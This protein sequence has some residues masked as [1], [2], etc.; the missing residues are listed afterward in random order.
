MKKTDDQILVIF[1]ASGDLTERKLIPAVFDLYCGGF[2]P[3]HFAVTG[4]SRS[5]YSDEAYRQKVVFENEFILKKEAGEDKLKAFADAIFYQPLDTKNTDSYNTLKQRLQ[6]IDEAKGICGNYIFY[7]ATP[8]SLYE[9]IAEG[10]S[11]VGLNKAENAWRRLIIEKPFGYDLES[12]K[13]LNSKLLACFDEEQ[14]YRIDH[15]LGKETVQNMFVT[16]FANSIFEPLWNRNYIHRVEITAAESV[17]LEKRGGYYDSAGALRDMVQ[18]HLFQLVALVAMEPPVKADA[19]SIRNEKMKV[20]QSLRPYT[21]EDIKTNVI[22]GQYL[23]SKVRGEDLPGYREEEGVKEGSKTE[24][25]VAM[26]FFID[27]WRWGGVPFYIRTG[28]RLPTRVTEVV[29]HFKPNHHHLFAHD[30]SLSNA[31]NTLVIRIQPNEGILLKFDMKIPGAGFRTE[32]VNMDFHYDELTDVYV[33]GAYERLILDCMQG[34]ATLYSRGDSTESAW[35]FVDT[36]LKAWEED[37]IPVYGYPAGT[38]GPEHA[39]N[40][41]EG[42]NMTWRYPCKNLTDDGNYCEL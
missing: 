26:K 21:K 5:E 30:K 14:L 35:Q 32:T 37:D 31:H 2:L 17:G 7:L 12:A 22:R 29:I 36:I 3:E 16:R 40:L 20:F 9:T 13:Q 19:E 41:I 6:T 42:E 25:Y 4:V 15:Y 10:L 27:N 8:P 28:K 23:G 1:G 18:N 33:P 38:W 34:D 39:D 24:T 11:H